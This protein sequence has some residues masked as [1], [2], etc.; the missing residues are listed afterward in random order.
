[1]KVQMTKNKVHVSTNRSKIFIFPTSLHFFVSF[2]CLINSSTYCYR[3]VLSLSLFSEGSVCV[4][5]C[6]ATNPS[7]HQLWGS[8]PLQDQ[9]PISKPRQVQSSSQEIHRLCGG[10]RQRLY[11]NMSKTLQKSAQHLLTGLTCFP[12][13]EHLRENIINMF[14][15]L[16]EVAPVG[17]VWP[18]STNHVWFAEWPAVVSANTWFP[19]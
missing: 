16:L 1:M 7:P 14:S 2:L 11:F 19:I 13:E 8:W 18:L 6:S 17:P 5:L 4:R 15:F 10:S 3:H 9:G 12:L